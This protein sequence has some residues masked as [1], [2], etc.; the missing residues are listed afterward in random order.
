M[1]EYAINVRAVVRATPTSDEASGEVK[2]WDV[3]DWEG[4]EEGDCV[5]IRCD[6]LVRVEAEDQEAAIKRAMEDAPAI[7]VEGYE[8]G[9]VELW[10][11]PG[12]DVNPE[13]AAESPAP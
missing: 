2:G 1:T 3:Y 9:D 7:E 11:D 13:Y 5:T 12:V 6:R 8:I 10:V 4:S